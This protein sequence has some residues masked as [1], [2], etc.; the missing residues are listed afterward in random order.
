LGDHGAD[1]ALSQLE[2]LVV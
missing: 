1:V 2:G